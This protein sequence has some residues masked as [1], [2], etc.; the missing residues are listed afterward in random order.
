MEERAASSWNRPLAGSLDLL[1]V[2]SEALAD[3]PLGDPAARPLYV[4]RPPGADAARGDAPRLPAIYMLQGFAGR[5]EEWLAPDAGGL[6][7]IE[8]ID[9]IFAARDSR[10]ALVVFVDAWTSRGGSQFL[11]STSTGRYLDYVCDEVIPFVDARYPTLGAREH[12]GVSGKSSGGY[13]ALVMSMLRPDV[14]GALASHAGDTLFECRY[15]PLFPVAARMLRDEFGGSWEAFERRIEAADFDWREVAVLFATYGTACAYTPDP[16]RPG[17]P[18]IPFDAVTGRP[19][20]AV[21]ARWLALDPVRMAEA[22]ADA[23][24]GMRRIHLDAGRQDEFFLDLG[25]QA[26]SSE[27]TRLGIEHSLDLFDGNH[28]GVDRRIPRRSGSWRRLYRSETSLTTAPSAPTSHRASSTHRAGS[29]VHQLATNRGDA[30]D[31]QRR[32]AP[33][34]AVLLGD[35]RRDVRDGCSTSPRSR[36]DL[37]ERPAAVDLGHV[38]EPNG[39]AAYG[40]RSCSINH[41][42]SSSWTL[43]AH[44]LQRA[45][46]LGAEDLEHVDDPAS[47]P[48]IRP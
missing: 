29:R 31:P 11:N 32:H 39:R 34:R 24:R 7:T 10:P 45:V 40:E 25:A 42:R 43:C 28:D 14:F 47:P 37:K 6:T 15:R 21:W 12:R 33:P 5:L 23:L 48:T 4:Y 27:L 30:V 46:E 3:N 36:V 41:E 13:G 26:L 18:L 20:D 8:R 44:Q 2:H 9:A 1:V 17:K 35:G 38:H 19:I 16:E 22:H